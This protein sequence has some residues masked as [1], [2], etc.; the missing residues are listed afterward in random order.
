MLSVEGM[1]EPRPAEIILRDL[2]EELFRHETLMVNDV[3]HI[4]GESLIVRIIT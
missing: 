4:I 3:W 2:F 1:V